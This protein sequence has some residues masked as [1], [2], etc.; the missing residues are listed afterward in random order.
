MRRRPLFSV[1]ALAGMLL[2][3]GVVWV[4]GAQTPEPG[5]E[6][7]SDSDPGAGPDSTAGAPPIMV[8]VAPSSRQL[9]PVAVALPK[10][11][12]AD[13]ACKE[14]VEIIRRDLTLSGYFLVLP[15]ASYIADMDR[16]SLRSTKWEDWF[17]VG[18]RYLV[19]SEIEAKKGKLA[20]EF[21]LY[22]VNQKKDIR[23]E[24]D[25]PGQVSRKA[26]RNAV[27]AF[28]NDVLLA[29]TGQKGPFGGTILFAAKT[30]L[31]TK[32]IFAV[33]VDGYGQSTI[34]AGKT[35]NML[36]S[37]MRGNV[38]Y[39]SFSSGYPN[40]YL[41]GT[42]ITSDG[43]HY[44]GA[45]LSPDGSV[46]AVAVDE[47]GESEIYLMSTS[48]ERLKNL[49]DNWADEVSPAWSPDGSQIAFVSNRTG[50]PQI[51]VMNRDGSGQRRLTMQG[52]YNS[53]PDF[54]PDGIIVFAG[55][56]EAHSDIFTVDLEGNIA[57]ITQ[58]QG[59]NKD[60][61][62][63]PDGRHVA[64]VSDRDDQFQIYLS[65]I[66]GRYQFPITDRNRGYS[67]LFWAR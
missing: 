63:S 56:D 41:N 46:L 12:D 65:T 5:T 25:N 32:G 24:H 13:D 31:Q 53:T 54:G 11:Q 9:D 64:F 60:P 52:G 21:R 33:G 23:V 16:E 45:R 22:D 55:M 18:A 47:D 61:T 44:R 43:R 15:E 26:L 14:A 8:T 48:G 49:T 40:I 28:V 34:A 3:L 58:D 66:D 62:I 27:H 39:T 67:T 20:M 7:T 50:S 30:G 37:M 1:G 57:R 17:N 51:Y 10:C 38:V 19:K 35:I 4:A 36:P 6:P 29:I 42:R 2:L 59:N